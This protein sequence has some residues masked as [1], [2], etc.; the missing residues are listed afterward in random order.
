MIA[1]IVG[2]FGDEHRVIATYRVPTTPGVFG[3]DVIRER[4]LGED[5]DALRLVIFNSD[6]RHVESNELVAGTFLVTLEED[7][8]IRLTR[9]P[10][11]LDDDG[12][13]SGAPPMCEL[14]GGWP[15]VF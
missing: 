11:A 2:T 14:P 5:L 15:F 3:I 10:V 6:C 12:N 1:S 9:S 13:L 8:A 7:D 4:A